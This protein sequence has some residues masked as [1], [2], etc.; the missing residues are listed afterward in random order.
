MTRNFI[1]LAAL[2][3]TISGCSLTCGAPPPEPPPDDAVGSID[4]V[5]DG[6]SAT[7]SLSGLDA[8]LRALQVDVVV[9]E[10]RA[11]SVTAIGPWDVVEAGLTAS[12]T[13]P[14]GGPK[15]HFTLVVADTRRL[16]VNDGPLARLVIDDG[17][18]VKLANAVAVDAD[19]EKRSV[20]VVAR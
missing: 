11:S 9:G 13:N 6:T 12:P 7:L 14:I 19:G 17:A 20:T 2:L 15:D 1:A 16:P 8:P 3:S 18:K 10:G 4:V 5:V